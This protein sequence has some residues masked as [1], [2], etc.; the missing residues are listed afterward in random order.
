VASVQPRPPATGQNQNACYLGHTKDCAGGISGEHHISEIVLEQLSEPGVAIDGVFW[1]RSGERKVVGINSL[2]ANILCARHNSALS[3]LD[4]GQFLRTVKRIHASLDTKS[5]SRKRLASIVSGEA[6]EQ[7]ILKVACGLFYSKI[8]FYDRQQIANDHAI[9]NSIIAEG[10]FSK[11]WFP[12]CGLYMRAAI[13]QRVAGVNAISMAPATSVSEKR[14]VGV[15]VNIIGL[16]FAVIFDPRGANP[17]QLASEGW[18]FRP[19]D[20]SETAD[21]LADSHLAGRSSVARD[22]D[23]GR[24]LIERSCDRASCSSPTA[25]ASPTNQAESEGFC[26]PGTGQSLTNL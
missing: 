26:P 3:A 13:G 10:L 2:T 22:R 23:D 5:P 1:L 20:V 18:R 25:L 14:Y 11:R 15:R 16:E 7:W 12:N 9:E 24:P 8:A 4:T 19:T 17:T 6:L 21:A